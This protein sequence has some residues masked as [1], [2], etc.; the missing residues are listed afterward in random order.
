MKRINRVHLSGAISNWRLHHMKYSYDMESLNLDYY[1]YD[2][3]I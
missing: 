3:D 2:I 1:M